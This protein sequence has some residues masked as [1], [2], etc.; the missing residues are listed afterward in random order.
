MGWGGAAGST[1]HAGGLHLHHVH[2]YSAVYQSHVSGPH[3]RPHAQRLFLSP[4]ALSPPY[5]T[6]LFF[7]LRAAGFV[8]GR[9]SSNNPQ[10]QQQQQQHIDLAKMTL[11]SLPRKGIRKDSIADAIFSRTTL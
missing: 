1:G 9:S 8:H 5:Q 11:T 4:L 3:R 2:F 10:L 6:T 7:F